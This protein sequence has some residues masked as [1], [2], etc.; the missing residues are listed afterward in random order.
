M[1]SPRVP[2]GAA[3]SSPPTGEHSAG[4]SERPHGVRQRLPL[5]H[6]SAVLAM[7]AITLMW[8]IA[9]VVTRH[10][11]SA[12]SFEVTFWRSA[13]NA[14]ALMVF[15]PLLTGP[16]SFVASVRSGGW[17]LLVSSL[18]W[19]VMYTA[20][21]VA[22]TMTTVANVLVTLATGPLFTALVARVALG[23]RLAPRTLA[24]IVAAGVGI[25]WMYAREVGANDARSVQGMLIALAVPIAGAVNWTLVQHNQR[26]VKRD[27]VPAV[28]LGAVISSLATLP[29]SLPFMASGHDLGLLALLGVVQLAIPCSLVMIVARSLS[30]PEVALLALLEVLFGVLWAWLGAGEEPSVHV[31][32]G[33]A[34]VLCALVGNEL[35]G[36][37]TTP[38][39]NP[40]G[41]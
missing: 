1:A 31:L 37:R 5:T 22:M 10:L 26:T 21:M 39:T 29:L 3:P 24:A 35:I 4:I 27:L 17:Q 40:G 11:D 28:L 8:S 6:R 30:A 32:M 41:D 20:F 18:C 7:V 13:F 38:R 36:L 25:A 9:G 2:E 34:L 23:H 12:Q 14:M 33:G 19:S 15:M 16:R